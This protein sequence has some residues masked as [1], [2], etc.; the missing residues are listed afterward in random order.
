MIKYDY[1]IVDLLQG[2]EGQTYQ[3]EDSITASKKYDELLQKLQLSN[4]FWCIGLFGV[5]GDS[6]RQ[7]RLDRSLK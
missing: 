2:T 3:F 1:F 6:W 7:L 4:V 5:I